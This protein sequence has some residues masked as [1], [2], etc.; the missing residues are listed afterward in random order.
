MDAHAHVCHP[1]SRDFEAM[2]NLTLAIWRA[3]ADYRKRKSSLK[4]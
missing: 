1:F 3:G 2:D 4:P